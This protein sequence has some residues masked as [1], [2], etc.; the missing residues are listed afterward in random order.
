[1]NEILNVVI[2]NQALA[3]SI[4]YIYSAF[5]VSF[6]NVVIY[7]LPI[8]INFEYAQ[9]IKSYIKHEDADVEKAYNSGLNLGLSKPN[10]RCDNCL[11]EI[12]LYNNIP[13]ISYLINRG[14]CVSC[15]VKYSKTHF[16]TELLI[17]LIPVFL[18]VIYGSTMQFVF[19][20]ILFFISYI[21]IRIDFNHK[22]IPN[23][24]IIALAFL[25]LS[26]GVTDSATINIKQSL[27]NVAVTYVI[28]NIF[29]KLINIKYSFGYGDV[30]LL[31]VLSALFGLHTFVFLLLF[32]SIV[33][34]IEIL[35]VKKILYNDESD[36]L[37]FGPSI[38]FSTMFF[39]ILERSDYAHLIPI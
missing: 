29:Y 4:I 37:A 3:I 34:I 10:S 12:K 25:I 2:N 38:M 15:G 5:I 21:I 7:R 19:S 36:E 6:S 22:I 11:S 28:L 23:Q 18:Y 39:Y 35:I 9:L 14:C 20:S 13:V 32:A 33:G 17:P 1:M 27:I 30:K 16:L 8:M 24:L 26:I 31:I